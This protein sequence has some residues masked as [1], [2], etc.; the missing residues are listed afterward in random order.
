MT[1]VALDGT[2][3]GALAGGHDATI[4]AFLHGPCEVVVG[5]VA[6]AEIEVAAKKIAQ[7]NRNTDRQPYA[8]AV[9]P[10]VME[11]GREAIIA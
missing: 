7:T 2:V 11:Q 6:T 10:L 9:Q 8:P 4:A 5:R 3:C 1:P